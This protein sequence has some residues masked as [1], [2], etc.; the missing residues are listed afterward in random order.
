MLLD[1]HLAL[2]LTAQPVDRGPQLLT[3]P[4]VDLGRNW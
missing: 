3:A 2:R 4:P 1:R